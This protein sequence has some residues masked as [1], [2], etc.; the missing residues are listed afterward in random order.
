MINTPF[1]YYF[2]MKTIPFIYIQNTK[3]IYPFIYWNTVNLTLVLNTNQSIR[4]YIIQLL[5]THSYIRLKFKINM[6][7]LIL[8]LIMLI[9][10]IMRIICIGNKYGLSI[11]CVSAKHAALRRK[12][13]DW[14]AR[15]QDNVS[16][17]SDM[18]TRRLVSVSSTIKIQLSVL[19]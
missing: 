10:N 2:S 8:H 12:S 17:W 6:K 5:V 15:N 7:R 16:E 1:I 19:D 9:F 18:S 14:L 13:K 3:T 4:S 11:C